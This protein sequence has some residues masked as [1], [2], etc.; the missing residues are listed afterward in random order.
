MIGKDANTHSQPLAAHAEQAAGQE[1]KVTAT[2]ADTPPTP[3]TKRAYEALAAVGDL[4]QQLMSVLVYIHCCCHP[5]LPTTC[6]MIFLLPAVLQI[7]R[8]DFRQASSVNY[9]PLPKTKMWNCKTPK[10]RFSYQNTYLP[11]TIVR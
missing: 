11:K 5:E 2:A 7:L 9:R 10:W 1:V 3:D 4:Q 8:V 6:T